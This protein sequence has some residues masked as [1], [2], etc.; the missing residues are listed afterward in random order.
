LKKFIVDMNLNIF[1]IIKTAL[2][3]SILANPHE[4]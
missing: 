4:A 3:H 1:K 2:K